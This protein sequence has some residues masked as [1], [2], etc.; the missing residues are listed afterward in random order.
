MYGL[1]RCKLIVIAN[2]WSMQ[3]LRQVKIRI[4]AFHAVDSLSIHHTPN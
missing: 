4:A 3:L 2:L 1:S